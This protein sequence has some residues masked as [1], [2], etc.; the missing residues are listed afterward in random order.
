M[1]IQS[2]VVAIIGSCVVAFALAGIRSHEETG[3]FL[4]LDIT[5]LFVDFLIGILVFVAGLAIML[6][7]M[8]LD[9]LIERE[10]RRKAI[11][12]NGPPPPEETPLCYSCLTPAKLNQHFCMNCWTPLTSHAEID[13]LGSIYARGDMYW[14]LTHG[15][16]RP[17]A[18][19]G[20]FLLVGPLLIGLPFVI[21]G[22]AS[23]L[24]SDRSGLR[25]S[26]ILGLDGIMMALSGLL[27]LAS[28]IVYLS[29]FIKAIGNYCRHRKLER[30]R[31]ESHEKE[32]VESIQDNSV[33]RVHP[34]PEP[35]DI[36]ETRDDRM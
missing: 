25:Q 18:M 35:T 16:T 27:V 36:R 29:I 8:V 11:A 32:E 2:K 31:S 34:P 17:M 5:V 6:W 7:F 10:A 24:L 22:F 15:P 4:G 33:D 12:A 26:G 30:L 9:R 23:E 28:E 19:I 14:K 3:E 1:R 21:I 13:P 20:A